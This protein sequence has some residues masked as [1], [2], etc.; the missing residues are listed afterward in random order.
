MENPSLRLYRISG[1]FNLTNNIETVAHNGESLT[2][3]FQNSCKIYVLFCYILVKKRIIDQ[4]NKVERPVF[5][6]TD[7]LG[8]WIFTLKKY[9]DRLPNTICKNWLKIDQRPKCK[10]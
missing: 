10:S 1:I 8:N 9:D 2:F 5:T 7:I 4:W 6:K 3:L